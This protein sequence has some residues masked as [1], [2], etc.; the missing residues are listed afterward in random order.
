LSVV[1]VETLVSESVGEGEFISPLADTACLAEK[2]R[3]P[4]A[5]CSANNG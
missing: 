1:A 3:R 4:G 5:D 2:S